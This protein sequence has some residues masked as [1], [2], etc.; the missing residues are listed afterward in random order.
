MS[1]PAPAPDPQ[2]D[3]AY[4]R[5]ALQQSPFAST[6]AGIYVLWAV[7]VGAGF[8]LVDVVRDGAWVG[9]Y[10]M[11]AAPLGWAAS[12]WI[13]HRASTR[14]G[15]LD[16]GHGL[17]HAG[18]WLAMMV[19]MFLAAALPARGLMAWEALGHLSLLF[20]ALCY[21]LAGLHLDRATLWLGPWMLLGYGLALLL[22]AW[23]WTVT[24][25]TIAVGLAATPILA[26]AARAPRA[27]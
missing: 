9:R 11:V 19:V 27:A 16:A 17:R 24:G 10:W 23:N 25:I 8:T 12:A 3:L 7:L 4:V 5:R 26:R 21:F 20:L 1:T 22:P 13:G 2:Q 6:P 14:R 18:H 15:Q